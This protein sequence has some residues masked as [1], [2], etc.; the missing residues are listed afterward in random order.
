M[1]LFGKLLKDTVGEGISKGIGEAVSKAFSPAAEIIAEKTAEH[2]NTAS[3]A[4]DNSQGEKNNGGLADAVK[5]FEES[6]QNY[7][8]NAIYDSVL[9][10]F[11]KWTFSQITDCTTEDEDEYISVLVTADLTDELV[12]QY[13]SLLSSNGF[14][15]DWQIKRKI[16]S[17]KEHCV[18][19]TFVTDSEIRYIIFK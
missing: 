3:D 19:F 9:R 11:P 4:L 16:I 10:N 15:G 13:Q 12:E 18:D 1:G 5:R 2:L 7:A 6:A 8:G 14:G 17:G